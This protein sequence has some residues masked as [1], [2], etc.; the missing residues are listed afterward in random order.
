MPHLLGLLGLAPALA[1]KSLAG[2]SHGQPGRSGAGLGACC[3]QPR[4]TCG[5]GRHGGGRKKC[6]VRYQ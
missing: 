3:C 2:A 5:E 6:N 4:M 1:A